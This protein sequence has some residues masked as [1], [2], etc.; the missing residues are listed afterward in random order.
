MSAAPALKTS[1]HDFILPLPSAESNSLSH[2]D[3][4]PHV[5][6]SHGDHLS[7]PLTDALH[8]AT[9]SVG[10]G[11]SEHQPPPSTKTTTATATTAVTA[12]AVM[13]APTSPTPSLAASA[14]KSIPPQ[15]RSPSPPVEVT[16]DEDINKNQN[17]R[18]NVYIS[19]IP[20]AFR[21]EEFRHLCMQFGR[22]EAAKLCVD[23]RNSP[24]K[25]YGFALYYS[26]ESAAAAIRGLNGSFLQGR[27]VQARL[28]DSH[29]TPQ[30]LGDEGSAAR[31]TLPPP[32]HYHLHRNE[33]RDGRGGTSA[34]RN[35]R[36]N[37]ILNSNNSMNVRR[38]VSP[39]G[40]A[41]TSSPGMQGG[42]PTPPYTAIPAGATLLTSPVDV[43]ANPIAAIPFDMNACYQ[44]MAVMPSVSTPPPPITTAAAAAPMHMGTAATHASIVSPVNCSLGADGGFGAVGTP[45]TGSLSAGGPAAAPPKT[46][47][48]SPIS[49]A[50]SPPLLS[51]HSTESA[52][53][54]S[55]NAPRVAPVSANTA[56]MILQAQ[57]QNVPA[58]AS[59]TSPYQIAYQQQQQQLSPPFSPPHLTSSSPPSGQV[60]IMTTT[61]AD[62]S[63]AFMYYPLPPANGVNGL[64]AAAV[65]GPQPASLQGVPPITA[66]PMAKAA[67]GQLP[68]SMMYFTVPNGAG[69]SM[70][71]QPTFVPMPSSP[72]L[73]ASMTP[74]GVSANYVMPFQ[75]LRQM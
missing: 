34:H 27:A 8:N 28:A 59:V 45:V 31:T 9:A 32:S 47:V 10:H 58:Y 50:L 6:G 16:D 68:G 36:N 66:V 46:A 17:V 11:M 13:A 63:P 12:A 44:Y 1:E 21:S 49:V 56:P 3:V 20:P 65:N 43:I 7:R 40:V 75:V 52:G 54:V 39:A 60:A 72:T 24:T 69:A 41:A 70:M 64:A 23:N 55:P 15:T 35:G 42:L 57:Q 22:V 5:S 19:G 33:P 53:S 29:A 14:G 2:T 48:L 25:A 61:G 67:V 4:A 71:P 26:M 18:R 30:P 74:N 37:A 62:G 51:S 73:T 38:G